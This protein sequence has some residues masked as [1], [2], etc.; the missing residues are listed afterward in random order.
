MR[1]WI[2]GSLL[3][4]ALGSFEQEGRAVQE[5]QDETV[6]STSTTGLPARIR[7]RRNAYEESG[8]Q[9]EPPIQDNTVTSTDEEK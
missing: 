1:K 7:A 3:L 4:G 8:I 6:T 5:E 2:I 9:G